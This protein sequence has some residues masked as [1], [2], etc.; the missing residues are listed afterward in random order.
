MLGPSEFA[1]NEVP[2]KPTYL[3]RG[4]CLLTVNPSERKM[5]FFSCG[6]KVEVAHYLFGSSSPG[7]ISSDCLRARRFWPGAH[8]RDVYLWLS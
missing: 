5:N 2:N 8:L 4:T 6:P 7:F 3:K 1:F